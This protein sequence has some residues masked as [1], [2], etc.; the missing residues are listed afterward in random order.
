MIRC[1]FDIETKCVSSTK[2]SFP[3]C[4]FPDFLDLNW[5]DLITLVSCIVY[6]V[7]S[8]LDTKA[9]F[10]LPST[11]ARLPSLCII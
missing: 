8:G 9:C 5:A 7:D 11:K 4:K 6:N 1:V 3:K 10:G 2:Y